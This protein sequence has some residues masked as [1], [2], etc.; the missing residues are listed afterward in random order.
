VRF[1]GEAPAKINRE[2]RVGG[3]RSDGY[4][5]I[6]SRVAAIDLADVIEVET[7]DGELALSC[8]GF[9]V[10]SDESNLVVRAGRALA[11]HLGRP[12]DAAIRLEKKIPVGAGLG[13]GSSDAARAVA[14]LARLW[15]ARL[16]DQDLRVVAASLGS[17]VPFFLV[18]GEAEVTGRGEHVT[19]LPD[20]EPADLLV[21]VPPFP[22]STAEVYA[23]H[24]RLQSGSSFGHRRIP[25]ALE[26]DSSGKFFGPND[27]ALAVLETK[28][29]MSILF[30]S[31]RS[32]ASESAITGSGSAIVLVGAPVDAEGRLAAR[33]PD[34]RVFRCRTLTR[35]E[36]RLRTES[37]GGSQWRSPR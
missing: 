3:L 6:R 24:R 17:D 34:A 29:E 27:L 1:S 10:P 22:L 21:L 8:E 23:T 26:V 33:H 16:T 4:H 14:L 28:A 25:A 31:A 20:F 36:Y 11:N 7:G 12:A 30:E 5:E 2:L 35:E 18:G 19:P 37:S 13:G 9:P 32:L 15:D